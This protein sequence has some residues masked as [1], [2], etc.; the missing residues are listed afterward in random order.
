MA[1]LPR[2]ASSMTADGDANCR[3]VQMVYLVVRTAAANALSKIIPGYFVRQLSSAR[4]MPRAG[5][6]SVRQQVRRPTG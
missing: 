2:T 1:G 6:P 3:A 5:E 4:P